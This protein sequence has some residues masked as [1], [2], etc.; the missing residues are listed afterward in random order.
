M[1]P[2]KHKPPYLIQRVMIHPRDRKGI[3]GYFSFDYMGSSEFEW[4]ALPK[5][6]SSMREH[7][8][9]Y[10]DKPVRIKD[11]K[12][13]VIWYVGPED[14]LEMARELFIDQSY[15]TRGWILKERTNMSYAYDSRSG[16]SGHL[17][18]VGWWA[19]D[20]DWPWLLFVKKEHAGEWISR[21]KESA[22]GT[23]KSSEG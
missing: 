15:G 4:G 21:M 9:V 16:V 14:T 19:I 23:S 11:E 20:Q 7:A 1:K 13:R 2:P 10:P 3:D 5:A 22:D 12:G 18:P 6:L 17:I 8:G